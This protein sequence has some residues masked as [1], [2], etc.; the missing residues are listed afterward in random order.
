MKNNASI[1][2]Q[3]VY[4]AET[5]SAIRVVT[6]YALLGRAVDASQWMGLCRS[7]GGR[8]G[9][10]SLVFRRTGGSGDQQSRLGGRDADTAGVGGSVLLGGCSALVL[11]CSLPVKREQ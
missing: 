3:A 4:A 1:T 9:V 8:G 2:E 10:Q 11:A 7:H 5:Y 6:V